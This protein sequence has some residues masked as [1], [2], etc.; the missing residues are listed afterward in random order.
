MQYYVLIDVCTTVYGDPP[1]LRIV[2]LGRNGRE[3]SIVGNL[4]L[5]REVFD[6]NYVLHQTERARGLVDGRCFTVVNIPDLLDVPN[7]KY[8]KELQQCVT[9]SAPGPHV[10]LLVVTPEEFTENERNRIRHIL[11]SMSAKSC[12]YSMVVLTAGRDM[13][14]CVDK[15]PQVHQLIEECRQR[16]LEIKLSVDQTNL[17]SSIDKIM[18]ENRGGHLSCE[19]CEESTGG[20]TT[21]REAKAEERS[22]GKVR[23]WGGYGK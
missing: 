5:G 8:I 23:T 6:L 20:A 18:S 4:L 1:E 12:D 14:T 10:L 11:D 13:E 17:I 16:Y 22:S 7:E 19:R 15:H 9:L 2:L 3:K 21:E